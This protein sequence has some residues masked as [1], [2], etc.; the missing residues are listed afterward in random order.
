MVPPLGRSK[1]VPPLLLQ[2]AVPG[3]PHSQQPDLWQSA[4][5]RLRH[6]KSWQPAVQEARPARLRRGGGGSWRQAERGG[7]AAR[8]VLTTTRVLMNQCSLIE[9][10]EFWLPRKRELHFQ[11]AHLAAAAACSCRRWHPPA[12]SPFARS[13]PWQLALGRIPTR[14]GKA[15]GQWQA[16]QWN[17]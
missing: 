4:L 14:Q 11:Q 5:H 1:A 9:G 17:M 8:Q 13:W 6:C 7:R 2:P 3:T 16:L 12:V 15:A 10:L